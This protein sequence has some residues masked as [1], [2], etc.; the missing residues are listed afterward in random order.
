M[1]GF[2]RKG[3]A[4]KL[5][6][7]GLL[8][9]IILL[10]RAG[11]AEDL[12]SAQDLG[13][14]EKFSLEADG[15]VL[16]FSHGLMKVSRLTD[17]IIRVRA[18]GRDSFEPD[19]SFALSADAPKPGQIAV[20]DDG[21][22]L[23]LSTSM[24]TL[25]LMKDKGCIRIYDNKDN[26][27]LDETEKG[28]VYFE[29]E[30]K[31]PI[32]IKEIPEGEHYYGFGEKTGPF[33][34]LG[35]RM[36]MWNSD[37]PYGLNTDPIYQSHP[38]YLALRKGISYGI[39]MDNSYRSVFDVG[40]TEHGK[41]VYSA[42]GGELNYYFIYG[43]KPKDVI[44]GYASLVGKF[45]LPPLWA[46]GKMQCR[47]S[48]A[49]ERQ[50]RDIAGKYRRNQ[51]PC[52]VIFLDIHYMDHYKVFTFN[53]KRFPDPKGLLSDLEKD[54]FKVITIVDPGVKIE[55][56]YNVYEEG[57]KN[58]YFVRNKNG[59]YFQARVWPG[60]VYFPDFLKPEVREWWGGLHK[61]LLDLGVDGIW[62]DMN[63]PAGWMKDVR[64]GSLMVPSGT[65][66]WLDMEHGTKDNPVPH[67][68]IH[69]VYALLEAEATYKGL[70]QIHPDKRP[71]VISR[72][73]YSGIQKYSSVWTGDNYAT[74][75]QLRMSPAMLLNLSISGVVDVGV[76][77]GGFIDAPSPELY[78][79]WIQ[80]GVFYP[81]CRTHTAVYMPPQ[82]P[83][84][85][86]KE[87][88]E[89]SKSAI[90]LRYRLLPYTYK[91]F[92]DAS[93]T[94][95]PI[96]RAMLLEF[97]DD[98]RVQGL[99]SQFMW[100]EWLLVAPVM[101]E[102]AREQKIYLPT[103]TWYR[104][105]NGSQIKGGGEITEMVD[106]WS[107]PLFVRAGGIVP[108]APVMN[109]TWEKPWSPL[110]LEFYVGEQKN[111]F[112]VYEDSGDG[113]DYLNG[114]YLLTRYCQLPVENG[115][116]ITKDDSKGGFQPPERE[117]FLRVFGSKKPKSVEI[118]S[119]KGSENLSYLYDAENSSLEIRV[120]DQLKGF[121]IRIGY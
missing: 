62:N 96:M 92:K 97:P 63:E 98:E 65:V 14:L 52:D 78:A 46:L 2:W 112:D 67:A 49:N 84:S 102:S 34:K 42:D 121:E 48:Y 108:L 23:I 26:L 76:D 4:S 114:K 69:N 91:Y 9:C 85:Y 90:E 103:G 56:G 94:G 36:V 6:R 54:G 39:F 30:G 15:V 105:E 118:S 7:T 40:K 111:C 89:V 88:M 24:L 104:F 115:Y 66:P 82:D 79:R 106:L 47:Y 120:K 37:M 95:L 72:A 17:G 59:G 28:G 81:F 25:K 41:F 44:Q 119:G 70:K 99:A 21:N 101:R 113:F 86:G 58:D 71:F 35:E 77:I 60:D 11:L 87:V 107:L 22:M 80:Q 19:Q 3:I 43:P 75:P 20:R 29:G 117:L 13:N 109:Y 27:L 51:V 57:L 1:K 53:N 33:D 8:L 16:K 83:F 45:P 50:V 64:L 68:K 73:G 32:L 5:A 55:K 38:F 10:A 93:E 61:F 74:W 116:R 18:T 100:G 12:N 31:K 110:T